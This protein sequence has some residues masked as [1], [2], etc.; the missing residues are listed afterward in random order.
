MLRVRSLL[1]RLSE[2]R[3]PLMLL[4]TEPAGCFSVLCYLHDLSPLLCLLAGMGW[5]EVWAQVCL[6]HPPKSTWGWEALS[7][8][9]R[10]QGNITCLLGPSAEGCLPA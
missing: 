1:S 5:G 6:N 10:A 2:H 7:K 4:E 9:G 8:P 3:I